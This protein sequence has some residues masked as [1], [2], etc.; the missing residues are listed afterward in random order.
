MNH[1]GIQAISARLAQFI[2]WTGRVIAWL[3]LAM[4]LVTFSVVMLRY[5]FDIGWIAL[6]ESISYMHSVVFL[7]GAAYT[8]KHNEHVRVDIIYSR[9]SLRGRALIDLLGHLFILMPVMLFISWVSWPYIVDA[10]AVFE[11][12]REAGGLPGV[13]LLKSLILVM[14]GLLMLQA[15]AMCIDAGLRLAGKLDDDASSR[16]ELL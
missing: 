3:V 1:H 10:W 5:V 11:S 9:L 16:Q 13:Y 14:C 6:Q 12:S 7:L 2:D 15:L 4:V 8:L